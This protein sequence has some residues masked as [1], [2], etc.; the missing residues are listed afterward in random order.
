MRNVPLSRCAAKML[1]LAHHLI[2]LHVF[3]MTA[4]K[5]DYSFSVDWFSTKV[6]RFLS[7]TFCPSLAARAIFWRSVPMR[8][9]QR[10]EQ[11]NNI[12]LPIRRR[13]ST[14]LTPGPAMRFG[15]TSV[16]PDG[17]CRSRC[18]RARLAMLSAASR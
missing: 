5:H 17:L 7:G 13:A 11:A 10:H 1:R 16:G 3:G 2:L 15:P 9:D 4:K 18:T 8:A 12:S 6:F 14:P